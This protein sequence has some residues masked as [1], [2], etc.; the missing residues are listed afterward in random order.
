VCEGCS[1]CWQ[2]LAAAIPD[3]DGLCLDTATLRTYVAGPQ[4]IYTTH[5]LF[6]TMLALHAETTDD[7]IVQALHQAL[8]TTGTGDD[9]DF[10]TII[11]ETSTEIKSHVDTKVTV[12]TDAITGAKTTIVDTINDQCPAP[13]RRR[14]ATPEKKKIEDILHSNPAKEAKSAASEMGLSDEQVNA[15]MEKLLKGLS[16]KEGEAVNEKLKNSFVDPKV[17]GS[18]D[19]LLGAEVEKNSAKYANDIAGRL[20]KDAVNPA[21]GQLESARIREINAS[22][23]NVRNL[24]SQARSL[25]LEDDCNSVIDSVKG[26]IKGFIT[27]LLEELLSSITGAVGDGNAFSEAALSFAGSASSLFMPLGFVMAMDALEDGG[28]LNAVLEIVLDVSNSGVLHVTISL[29]M[30]LS[31]G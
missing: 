1:T 22:L 2:P 20:L 23:K 26:E 9:K 5:A 19:E 31:T 30:I 17:L 21:T 24:R 4:A 10:K 29:H 27:T 7:V 18:I 25:G 12:V 15:V 11:S 13:T 28:P 8:G 14:L 3:M 16:G 6:S